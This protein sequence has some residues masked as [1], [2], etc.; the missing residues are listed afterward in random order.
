M[1]GR[2]VGLL[3]QAI[4]RSPLVNSDR[5]TAEEEVVRAERTKTFLSTFKVSNFRDFGFFLKT[6]NKVL[7]GSA[8]KEM[9]TSEH[10]LMPLLVI[11]SY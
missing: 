3:K 7:F 9:V 10:N 11:M 1:Y 5:R 2:R 6:Q 4:F 8:V